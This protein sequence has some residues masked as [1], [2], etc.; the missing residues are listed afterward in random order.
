[1]I[2]ARF[3]CGIALF[4]IVVNAQPGQAGD[5]A[6]DKIRAGLINW[7]DQFN[8]RDARAICDLFAPDV[9]AV[10]QG[11]PVRNFDQ[12]CGLL[13]TS[14]SDAKRGY[15]YDLN[16]QD[17]YASGDLGAVRLI[18][19]LKVADSNG[20]LIETSVEPGI[21]IFQRQPD[22]KWKIARYL[23]FAEKPVSH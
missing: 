14:L 21:D 2:G 10:F 4:C 20:T 17:V 18:W 23:S 19:T 7:K 22:G 1:M 3:F 9:V 8:A 12:L 15:H 16:I 13:R 5:T 11:Q 6:A